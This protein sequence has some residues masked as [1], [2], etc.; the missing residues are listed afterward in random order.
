LQV[1]RAALHQWEEPPISGWRGSGTVFFANCPLHCIY[2]Q[3]LNIAS[4]AVGKTIDYLRLAE[5]FLEL[6]DQAAHNINLVTPTQYLPQI[7]SALKQAQADGLQVPVVYNTGGYESVD[8]IKL[9]KGFINIYLTDFKY[10]SPA[11]AAQYSQASDYAAVALP[12]LQAMAEQVGPY[13]LDA[14]GLLQ[15]GVIVRHLMLPGQLTDSKAVISTVFEVLGNRVCYSLMNQYTPLAGAQLPPE[16]QATV[17]E[18]EYSELVDF[19]LELGITNSFMQEG[20]TATESFIPPFDLT[21]V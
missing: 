21:G 18:Q 16:L 9:L 19:A 10:F 4:G 5:I 3:N 6:Q 1:A 12:A 14:D 17:S 20:G 11:L 2:C 15:S 13:T 7:I 8:T